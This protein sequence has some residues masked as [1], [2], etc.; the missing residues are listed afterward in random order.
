MNRGKSNTL[1]GVTI[2]PEDSLYKAHRAHGNTTE[3][4][5]ILALLIFILSQAPLTSW[6]LWSMVLV[7]LS[8]YIFVV[9]IL[10]PQT[11]DKP[12]PLRFVGSLG[13]Y[14]GGFALIVALL[15]QALGA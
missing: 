10:V 11:M 5:P 3:Y 12:H 8:R 1:Y 15:I 2:D 7:T 9:G 6:V 13:T 4:A 14:L